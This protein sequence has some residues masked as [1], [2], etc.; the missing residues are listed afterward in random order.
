MGVTLFFA[1]LLFTFNLI[2][3]LSYPLVDP[4]MAYR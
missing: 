3:D 4:R 2:V 1:L